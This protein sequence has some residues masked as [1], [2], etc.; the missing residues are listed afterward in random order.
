MKTILGVLLTIIINSA[1]ADGICAFGGDKMIILKGLTL[2]IINN[3]EYICDGGKWCH[4][5]TPVL[6]PLTGLPTQGE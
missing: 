6:S 1:H 3:E 5:L 4:K 2:E